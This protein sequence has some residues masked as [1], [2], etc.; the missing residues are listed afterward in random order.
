MG[1]C[2]YSMAK[3]IDLNSNN[4]HCCLVFGAQG[5][6]GSL[7]SEFLPDKTRQKIVSIGRRESTDIDYV[8]DVTN[9]E[10]VSSLLEVIEKEDLIIKTV[11]DFSGV[12]Q[13]SFLVKLN[14][15]E[16]KNL[17]DVNL[18]GPIN[19]TKAISERKKQEVSTRL[20]LMSSVVATNQLN[21]TSVY[22][23]TKSALETFIKLSSKELSKFNVVI[24]GIRLGYFNAGMI[25]HVPAELIDKIK[26]ENPQKRLGNIE[27]LIPLLKFLMD[28]ATDYVNGSII[29]LTGGQ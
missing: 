21:G 16:L 28:D 14:E 4:Q 19:L 3:G 11:I 5:G 18:L 8:C 6:L 1:S 9:Y 7:V 22:G 26:S 10:Q 2:S 20:I 23:T 25:R 17:I 29:T 15:S 24:N 27:D 13:Q 12:S